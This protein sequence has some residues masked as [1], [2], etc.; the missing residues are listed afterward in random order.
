MGLSS[1]RMAISSFRYSWRIGISVALGV[2][3]ATAV[4]VGAL[5]VGDSMRGSLREL[6]LQRLGKIES[7]LA[8]G[9]FF[10]TEGMIPNEI[11]HAAVIFFNKGVIEYR[12]STDTVRRSGN[13][14]IVGC[15]RA[16]WM[17]DESLGE[18]I[19]E[20]DENEVIINQSVADELG[21]T[22]GD[23][24]NVRL[25]VEQAVPAD[26]PLGRRESNTEGIPRL[27]IIRIVADRGLARFSLSASQS[28]P[29]NIFLARKTIAE[30]LERVG[31]ANMVL[32]DQVVSLDD[33]KINLQTL[34]MKLSPISGQWINQTGEIEKAFEY[35]SLTS[36]SLLIPDVVA[37][38]ILEIPDGSD[39]VLQSTYLA[40][41]IETV[42]AGG[43]VIKS[44]P[45]STITAV[46]SSPGMPLDFTRTPD[47]EKQ[48]LV[49]V[50]LNQWAARELDAS[51]GAPL[52]I[53]YFE[54]EVEEGREVERSFMAVVTSI[55]PF[56][57]PD[58]PYRRRREAVFREP[59]S[60]YNDPALTPTVPGITDQDSIADWDL[61]FKLT[62]K[63]SKAD[64]A[65]WNNHRLTPKLFLP[66]SFGRQYFGSRFG[67]V[68][69]LRFPM[70]D[71]D[72]GKLKIR[73][74]D[75]LRPVLGEI[76]WSIIPIK[77][78]QLAAAAG[79]TP[80][81]G[82]F[83]SLS[84]FVIAA[85]ILLI[86]M[87]FRLG[88]IHRMQQYGVLLITGWSPAGLLR[89]VFYEGFVT[90]LMGVALGV[91]FGICYAMVILHA[92]RTWWVDAVTVPFLEFHWTYRSLFGGGFIGL[93]I[94]ALT[95][96]FS[97]RWLSKVPPQD[98]LSRKNPDD[99]SGQQAT[100]VSLFRSKLILYSLVAIAVGL[101]TIGA[102]TGGQIAAGAFVSSG[103]ALLIASL[104]ACHASLK[105][106]NASLRK[107]TKAYLVNST[108]LATRNISR[109][110]SRSTTTVGLIASASF[111][112]FAISAFHLR[113]TSEGTGGFQ[114]IGESSQPIYEDLNDSSVRQ[115]L[116]GADAKVLDRS[117]VEMFRL[118]IGQDASCNNLYRA[119]RPTVLGVPNSFAGSLAEAD[120]IGFR[121]AAG[122]D[123]S[124]SNRNWEA[125]Q[126]VAT[127]THDD[128]IPIVLDQNTAMWSLQL[129]KG[130]GE[131]V[132]FE[133][134]QG[135]PRVFEVVGL[136]SNSVMQGKLLLSE[137]NFE[138]LFPNVSGYQFF[139]V[140]G[141]SLKKESVEVAMESR[142][143]DVGM[144]L[145][146]SS[147]LLDRMLA[148]QNTYLRTFQ[149]LGAIGLLL[150]TIGLA[151]AQ[152]RSVLERQ[153]EFA[154]LRSVGFSGRKLGL[155]VLRET[156]LLLL[157]GVGLGLL[158]SILAVLPHA[159]ISGLDPPVFEPLYMSILIVAFGLAI[160]M[161]AVRQVTKLALLDS[162][163]KDFS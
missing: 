65:Y 42:T 115:Q 146:D 19:E 104:F 74:S 125:L 99:A 152:V 7:I 133:L 139:M 55:V 87:L 91:V 61:P 70:S 142:F 111:L 150:G 84:F 12:V 131:L 122:E 141:D 48:S 47:Q 110:A 22:V 156:M 29:L 121:W 46:D 58:E 68:T 69:S 126:R 82:L 154:I 98:L 27:K 6:T 93:L 4:I 63:I 129:M 53:S 135:D 40:N 18:S 28:A 77:S 72:A 123:G 88:L 159:L 15:D 35:N 20:P 162:L 13:V 51:I 21:V 107:S 148:V 38:R 75:A 14:Q 25:P 43:E 100:G 116:M 67:V 153:S 163:R 71:A 149:S 105:G 81:D 151:I 127:G 5:L 145:S 1:L 85:A 62:R 86:A 158:T 79:T 16:F 147:A 60:R 114:L 137:S 124:T 97:A 160:S 113:P 49:P 54:P 32:F 106:N 3:I 34:G 66:L 33:L 45:Y 130:L 37:S 119:S 26:S 140:G 59:L 10:A 144:D 112:I 96:W 73:L 132:E 36:D 103:M 57:E 50:V 136:L 90:A 157:L 134:T 102:L 94:A 2:G 92:L 52:K 23:F 41:A 76:G 31:Q 161:V 101:S 120:L 83:L 30:S 143:S 117:F 8:P 9:N 11:P 78:D 64:D 17:L 128:P 89:Y 56:I 39:A 44:I 80:F 138:S 95:L 109:Y 108:G 24:V 118:K 155:L